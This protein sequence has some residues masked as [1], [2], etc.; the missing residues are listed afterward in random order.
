MIDSYLKDLSFSNAS[1]PSHLRPANDHL[2]N[3]PIQKKGA[4]SALEEFLEEGRKVLRNQFSGEAELEARARDEIYNGD[5][6]YDLETMPEVVQQQ[7]K[8]WPQARKTQKSAYE[9]RETQ[10]YSYDTKE[11]SSPTRDD[12]KEVFDRY[13]AEIFDTKPTDTNGFGGFMKT[14]SEILAENAKEVKKKWEKLE[15]D[16]LDFNPKQENASAQPLADF[17][18]FSSYSST[19]EPRR[20]PRIFDD[21]E[22]KPKQGPVFE[23]WWDDP[24]NKGV[25][26]RK[27]NSLPGYPATKVNP[28]YTVN[29]SSIGRNPNAFESKPN[30][31]DWL[32][33]NPFEDKARDNLMDF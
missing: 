15:S 19:T 6:E 30:P 22:A 13:A 16:F 14:K 17:A 3:V 23:E 33:S 28:L 10:K 20:R 29:S 27:E 12:R 11:N 21:V 1:L 2:T 25:S 4:L 31:T 26:Q 8:E 7:E 5:G 32:S 9:T 24:K 18:D